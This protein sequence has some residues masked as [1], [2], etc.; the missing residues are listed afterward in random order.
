MDWAIRMV[1]LIGIPAALALM[2]LAEPI[3]MALFQYD[4]MTERD[5]AMAATSLRAYSIGLLA[6]MLI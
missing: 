3:L 4:K 6:F 2:V 5:V 1:L